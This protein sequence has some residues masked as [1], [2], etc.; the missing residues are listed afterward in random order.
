[1]T[2][3][4][5]ASPLLGKGFAYNLG[6]ISSRVDL[7][8]GTHQKIAL[9][10][11][12]F[13]VHRVE[14]RSRGSFPE[15]IPAKVSARQGHAETTSLARSWLVNHRYRPLWRSSSSTNSLL[16]QLNADPFESPD[17]KAQNDRERVKKITDQWII[18]ETS[19]V[20][21][22]PKY[23]NVVFGLTVVLVVGGFLCGLL[24]GSRVEGFDPFN[25]TAFSWL[26]GWF[27]LLVAKVVRV[28]D[29]TWRDFLQRQ[30]TCRSVCEVANVSQLSQ[31]EVLA[32]L[33]SSGYHHILRTCGPFQKVFAKKPVEN[34]FSIDVSPDIQTL[35][36][37][38]V[39]PVKVLTVDGEALMLLNLVSGHGSVRNIPVSASTDWMLVCTDLPQSS[40]EYEDLV[41]NWRELLDEGSWCL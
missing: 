40:E 10:N 6:G 5:L 32:Y 23:V 27:I 21:K 38:G 39:I 15:G 1:M 34:S 3:L 29:W 12:F 22:C 30:V 2:P 28:S 36:A 19:I 17:A 20:I 31:Q 14:G 24:V 18:Q 26:L 37:S 11:A 41:L 13:S 35:L 25:F 16:Q 8:W 9:Q 7:H 4:S 33:I